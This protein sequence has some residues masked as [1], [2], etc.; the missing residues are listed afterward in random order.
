MTGPHARLALAWLLA[1]LSV[2]GVG[3][4]AE[5]TGPLWADPGVVRLSPEHS[6]ALVEIHNTSGTPRPISNIALRGPNWDTLRFVDETHPRTIPAGGSVVIELE[7]SVA[8]YQI[9][10]GRYD[11]GNATLEF[12]SN[13]HEYQLPIQFV[14]STP[15]PTFPSLLSWLALLGLASWVLWTPLRSGRLPETAQGRALAAAS[16]AALLVAAA[17]IPLDMGVSRDRLR[18]LVG[19]RELGSY[20]E[21]FEAPV[22]PAIWWWVAAL[23]IASVTLVLLRAHTHSRHASTGPELALAGLRALGVTLILASAMLGLAPVDDSASALILAQ[24][25]TI[26][27]AGVTLPR[28]GLIAQPLGAVLA[29][30]LVASA[31][32]LAPS[33][34]PTV[35]ALERLELLV[36]VAVLATAFIGGPAIPWISA[37]PIPLLAHGPMVALDLAMLIL[38]VTLIGA[39]VVRLRAHLATLG[40]DPVRLVAIHSRWT[41]PLALLQLVLVLVW[42]AA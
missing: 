11:A 25:R 22:A 24:A 31:G 10:P 17:A 26:E 21:L 29:F 39:L 18:E 13:K 30:A 9:Q 7:V 42:R 32:P 23:T 12:A 15:A 38:A 2:L 27:I 19:P 1:L 35:S 6:R 33:K 28:W 41:I 34:D 8:S 14:G 37:R 16:L 40:L 5:T 36:W 4:A 20:R 3:C